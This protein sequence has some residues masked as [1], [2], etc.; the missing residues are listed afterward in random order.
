MVGSKSPAVHAK[1][2]QYLFVLV[3]MYPFEGVLDKYATVVDTY[4]MQCV[5]DANSEARL[6][7]RKSYFVWGKLAPDNAQSL[8]QRFDY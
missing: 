5:Q 8:F 7:G 4:V 1:M 3:S 6:N 2:S